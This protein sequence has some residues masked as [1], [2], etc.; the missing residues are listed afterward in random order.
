[1]KESN[2][3]LNAMGLCELKMQIFETLLIL[4]KFLAYVASE[5]NDR[6]RCVLTDPL[7]YKLEGSESDRIA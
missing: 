6:A 3:F 4:A 7:I 5:I 2:G 1:M